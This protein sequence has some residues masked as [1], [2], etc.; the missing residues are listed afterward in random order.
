VKSYPFSMYFHLG[1]G[2]KAGIV[3]GIGSWGER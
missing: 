3:T 1:E 2:G